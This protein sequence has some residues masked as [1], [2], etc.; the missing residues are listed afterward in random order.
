MIKACLNVKLNTHPRIHHPVQIFFLQLLA[1]AEGYLFPALDAIPPD[2]GVVMRTGNFTPASFAE[3]FWLFHRS[4]FNFDLVPR[5]RP[6]QSSAPARSHR[7]RSVPTKPIQDEPP[8][9]ER[10]ESYPHAGGRFVWPQAVFLGFLC[11]YSFFC[12]LLCY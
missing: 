11:S 3:N 12:I 4:L 7:D 6:R 1:L 5:S 2:G 9:A 8:Q 10:C